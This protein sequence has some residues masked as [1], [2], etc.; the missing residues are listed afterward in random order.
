MIV[1]VLG[2]GQWV[3]EVEHLETLNAVDVELEEAVAA[4]DEPAMRDA[5]DRLFAGIREL[6]TEVPIDVIVESDLVMPDPDASL[7][8]VRLLLESTS[9]YFGILPDSIDAGEE[10]AER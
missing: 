10:P 2:E 6:G 3:L 8:E 5:L 1:R 4:G 9:E 7:E